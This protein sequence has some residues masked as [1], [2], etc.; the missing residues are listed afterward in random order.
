MLSC[1]G[2]NLAIPHDSD[3]LG[4]DILATVGG[5]L[6]VHSSTVALKVGRHVGVPVVVSDA[7]DFGLAGMYRSGELVNVVSGLAKVLVGEG[8]ASSYH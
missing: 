1:S 2:D 8:G 6:D 3:P 7:A 4:D 5:H